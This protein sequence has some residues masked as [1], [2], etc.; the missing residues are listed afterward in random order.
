MPSLNQDHR[1]T[2]S[3]LSDGPATRTRRVT[4]LASPV[5]GLAF[6]FASSAHAQGAGRIDL[7]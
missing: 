6:V 4:L 1:F 3:P 7:L 2:M 5:L